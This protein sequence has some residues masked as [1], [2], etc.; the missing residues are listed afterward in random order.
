MPSALMEALEFA[1]TPAG[2]PGDLRKF[3]GRGIKQEYFKV[4]IGIFP[5]QVCCGLKRNP[6]AVGV[7]GWETDHC[8][9]NIAVG[10]LLDRTGKLR[11]RLFP[12]RSP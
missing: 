4:A 11:Q 2:G 12:A 3:A 6:R 1:V 8:A 7:H 9:K 10:D 5:G